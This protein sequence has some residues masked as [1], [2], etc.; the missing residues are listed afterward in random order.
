MIEHVSCS[1]DLVSP[2]FLSEKETPNKDTIQS[3]A[4]DTESSK[5]ECDDMITVFI[6]LY[7]ESTKI[8]IN[9]NNTVYHLKQHVFDK[10]GLNVNEQV[11][12]YCGKILENKSK[13][14]TYN[15]KQNNITIH[16]SLRLKA[17]SKRCFVHFQ[18]EYSSKRKDI[19]PFTIL[20]KAN[21]GYKLP[22][23]S[24]NKPTELKIPPTHSDVSTIKPWEIEYDDSTTIEDLIKIINNQIDR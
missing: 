23:T 10:L 13:L 21:N 19:L 24:D 14:S 2:R 20:I 11:L 5:T 17:A 16:C 1:F 12:S 7:D 18:S 22:M 4:I 9:I 3:V 8:D 15:I 6:R